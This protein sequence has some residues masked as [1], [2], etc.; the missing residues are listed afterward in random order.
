MLHVE[1]V[2]LRVFSQQAES[3]AQRDRS[4]G[5]LGKRISV[6]EADSKDKHNRKRPTN[7][8][9]WQVFPEVEEKREAQPGNLAHQSRLA[10]P[11]RLNHGH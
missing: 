5:T 7:L 3:P 9:G 10:C 1:G 4:V 2:A 6:N 8:T 11:R